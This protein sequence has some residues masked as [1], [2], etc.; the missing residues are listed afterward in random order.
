MSRMPRLTLGRTQ[1]D[2]RYA[3]LRSMAYVDSDGSLTFAGECAR[4]LFTDVVEAFRLEVAPD[5]TGIEVV[6]QLVHDKRL[7]A[8][9][10]EFVYG[11]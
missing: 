4:S 9:L 1:S 6:S 10:D 8:E 7:R 3:I 11:R 2:E 5:S